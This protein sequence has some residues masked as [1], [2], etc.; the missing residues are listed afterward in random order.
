MFD[1]GPQR[2]TGRIEVRERPPAR[3]QALLFEVLAVGWLDGT[4]GNRCTRPDTCGSKC[5]RMGALEQDVTH[6]RTRGRRSPAGAPPQ[7]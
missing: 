4:A 6:R 7:L 1:E 5:E 2:C 3:Y